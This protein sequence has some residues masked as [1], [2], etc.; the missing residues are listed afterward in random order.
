M[1]NVVRMPALQGLSLSRETFELFLIHE[2]KLLDE[3]RFRDW[4]ELFTEDGAY[5]VP[6]TPNQESPFNYASLF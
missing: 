5:W 3:R 4:M 2:A 6:A 1:D